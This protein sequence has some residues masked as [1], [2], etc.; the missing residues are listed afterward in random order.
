MP[1][2]G[3]CVIEKSN[4]TFK[5]GM[6]EWERCMGTWVFEQSSGWKYYRLVGEIW[7]ESTRVFKNTQEQQQKTKLPK[8]TLEGTPNLS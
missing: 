5:P 3:D 1:E 4:K 2:N 8:A 7:I 6:L